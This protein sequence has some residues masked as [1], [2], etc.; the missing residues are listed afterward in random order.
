MTIVE[1]PSPEEVETTQPPTFTSPVKSWKP[2]KLSLFRLLAIQT[3][4]SFNSK[5]YIIL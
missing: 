2:F 5:L 4:Y 1:E 3:P